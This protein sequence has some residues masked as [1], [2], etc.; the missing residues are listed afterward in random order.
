MS[1]RTNRVIHLLSVAVLAALAASDAAAQS[2]E[3]APTSNVRVIVAGCAVATRDLKSFDVYVGGEKIT[4]SKLR[5]DD[6]FWSGST[7]ATFKIGKRSLK[8]VSDG[9]PHA[10]A[11]CETPAKG[12]RD[13]ACVAVYRVKCE[14]LWFVDVALVPKQTPPFLSYVRQAT[15]ETVSACDRSD[16]PN[17]PGT[18]DVGDTESL[19][20]KVDKPKCQITLSR[21]S[22]KRKDQLTLADV[23]VNA[24]NDDSVIAE[25]GAS[26]DWARAALLKKVKDMHFTKK[27]N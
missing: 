15:P 7:G 9:I 1:S 22:F 16:L 27:D 26:D 24:L 6:E 13:G 21:R 10:L 12:E 19:L 2:C 8:I 11:M 4:V 23:P 18:V 25:S 3:G 5:P 14:T 17:G 20:V